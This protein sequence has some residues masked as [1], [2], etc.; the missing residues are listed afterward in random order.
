ME[1][2]GNGFL[3]EV[4]EFQSRDKETNELTSKVKYSFLTGDEQKAPNGVTYLSDAEVHTTI[5]DKALLTKVGYLQRIKVAVSVKSQWVK[6][7]GK[8]FEEKKALYRVVG[9]L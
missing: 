8:A 5:S 1:F 6:R 2:I 4:K 3:L 9:D 7:D